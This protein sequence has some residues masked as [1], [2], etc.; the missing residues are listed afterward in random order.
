VLVQNRYY[1]LVASKSLRET[2]TGFVLSS[3]PLLWD[4]TCGDYIVIIS[5][6]YSAYYLFEVFFRTRSVSAIGITY[7]IG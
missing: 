2:V 6:I 4:I 1:L 7:H 3:Y 5:Q